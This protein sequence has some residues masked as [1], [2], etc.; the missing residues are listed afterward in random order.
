MSLGM[1]LLIS[2]L[3]IWA[4]VKRTR[5]ELFILGILVGVIQ[6]FDGFIG[7]YQHNLGKSVGPFALSILQI[8]ALI[9]V[10]KKEKV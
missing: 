10:S 3:A 6:F 1:Q 2:S 8:I 5:Q 4:I 7:L 9:M